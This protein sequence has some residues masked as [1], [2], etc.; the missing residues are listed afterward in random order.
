[1][2]AHGLDENYKYDKSNYNEK[3]IIKYTNELDALNSKY[4]TDENMDNPK[5][6]RRNVLI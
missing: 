2:K 5:E 6:L 4:N 1:M 3:D